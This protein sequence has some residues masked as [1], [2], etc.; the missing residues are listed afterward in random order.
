MWGRYG[1]D[2]AVD[3]P[4]VALVVSEFNAD[5]TYAMLERAKDHAAFLGLTVK[6]IVKVP[7]VYDMPL[8]LKKLVQRSDI[9]AVVA[10]GAVI[11]G[12]TRHDEVVMQHTARKIADLS[13]DY[14]KPIGLGISGPGQ[15]RLQALDRVDKA[16]E[17][18][19]SV[20]KLLKAVQ[21]AAGKAK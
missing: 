20:A 11:E 9:D 7:G 8:V 4:N 16:R 14:E 1:P 18:M 12:E 21:Q 19:E 3:M 17:A 5:V 6:E 10:L 2:E 15:T 13:V